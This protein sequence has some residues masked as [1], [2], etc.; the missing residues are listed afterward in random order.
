MRNEPNFKHYT[1]GGQI[2]FHNLRMWDQITKTLTFICLFLWIVF[3]G[4]ITWWVTSYEQIQQAIAY[5]YACFLHLV[6]QKHTFTLP[7]HGKDYHQTVESLLHYSYFKSNANHMV[8][9]LGKS[10]LAAF[11][12]AFFLGIALAIYFIKR[13]KAQRANQFI[14]GSQLETQDKVKQQ[15]IKDKASSDITIDGFP[16][17]AGS[18]VQHLLVHGTVGTGKSQLIMKILDALR[19]RGDRVIIYDKGAAFI[20]HYF[21]S[22]SDVLLNPFDAR[23]PNW[24][25]WAEAP[26]DSDFENMAE[27]LIPMHG[28]S[29]PFWVNAARTV[30][31]SC[32][33]RM[34]HDPERSIE[35]LLQ[36]LLSCEF[37]QLEQYLQGTPAATLV[38]GKI[39]KT[40]ISI[41]S[42]I[43]TYLKSLTTLSGLN[44]EHSSSFSIREFIMNEHH[45]GW[46]F[47]SSNGEQ[48]T[49]LKPLISMWLAMA[50]LTL[51]SLS[52]NPDR[53]I[54]FICDELPSLHKLP[55][56]GETIAEVRKFGGCFLLG[57]QSVAQL[58]KVYGQAGGAKE[59]FDLLN[60]R[61]FFRSPSADM[62]RLVAS[63]L[64]EEE[65]E[66]SRE[67]YSYGANSIRDG[68]SLGS[69][70]VTRSI[71]S[72]PQILELK[73]LTC[74][75]R[76]PGQYPVT[77]LELIHQKRPV[78]LQ[79]FVA[80]DMP[81]VVHSVPN[82]E[83]IALAEDESS[84]GSEIEP[85]PTKDKESSS[86]PKPRKRKQQAEI[87]IQEEAQFL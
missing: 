10:A 14:R 16:L 77:S 65:I 37:S 58:T 18:E 54:W 80:R 1:R 59:L 28:E 42:V 23:C 41:R 19:Q 74:F 8:D 38:S 52:P 30:F 84:V 60:T 6:G 46:L 61:F 71:V 68:I 49:T 72:Y 9:L 47:I 48:H 3:T 15:I 51:L 67:N 21:D 34:R 40:A 12:L 26:R 79:G 81:E 50:S 24:D 86:K 11:F 45:N 64:G 43:T 56:L 63:E 82:E 5:Y 73:D 44:S 32:A 69:Q 75:V 31:S 66:E 57:M 2:S 7:F 4:V 13:G 78:H 83:V 39:E 20:P 33:S 27:S 36:L 85:E 35:K 87:L 62:A 29:E 22:N 76:L 17:L 53:R 25:M 55:L 70:R